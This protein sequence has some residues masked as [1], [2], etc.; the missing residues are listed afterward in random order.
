MKVSAEFIE[1]NFKVL[2]SGKLEYAPGVEGFSKVSTPTDFNGEVGS[3]WSLGMDGDIER[4]E[5]PFSAMEEM[6]DSH[7]NER[8]YLEHQLRDK[9][10]EINDL[11]D[12]LDGEN[13]FGSK[14]TAQ[15]EDWDD[16]DDW[17][18][19]NK[20]DDIDYMSDNRHD[21][22][23]LSFSTHQGGVDKPTFEKPE[24]E[25][26]AKSV[27]QQFPWMHDAGWQTDNPVGPYYLIIADHDAVPEGKQASKKTAQ[28]EGGE[29]KI[30]VDG[31]KQHGFLTVHMQDTDPGGDIITLN[32]DGTVRW[33]GFTT[34]MPDDF[35]D[36]TYPSVEAF[37][38]N[39]A[40]TGMLEWLATAAKG[41][42]MA[43]DGPD[44][45]EPDTDLRAYFSEED[46]D[47]G[48]VEASAKTAQGPEDVDEY[49]EDDGDD[50]SEGI[51]YVISDWIHAN[52]V[53]G[54]DWERDNHH[55]AELFTFSVART[56]T[57]E[58]MPKDEKVEAFAKS[59]QKQFPWMVDEGWQSS[60]PEYYYY[61][62]YAGH[63]EAEEAG[64]TASKK[65]AQP[66]ER[67][68]LQDAWAVLPIGLVSLRNGTNSVLGNMYEW[69]PDGQLTIVEREQGGI[70]VIAG[71]GSQAV[72][73]QA[74]MKHDQTGRSKG[75]VTV[76]GVVP[77]TPEGFEEA[78]GIVGKGSVGA[79]VW[80]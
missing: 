44:P 74:E 36:E 14:K 63:D 35:R 73:T 58:P 59:V 65:T 47:N 16:W 78:E 29:K 5:N 13:I 60:E 33:Q 19:A 76:I 15:D 11:Q 51:W 10:E 24:V 52:E 40:E 55:D 49:L 12:A 70:R 9:A 53:E 27:V 17:V 1:N 21:S 77:I 66:S 54:V 41:D 61:Q 45:L 80:K 3:I 32:E 2:A 26:F 64:S 4:E 43:S 22:E 62:L 8:Q 25:A 67:E 20:P 37:V 68:R 48:D 34:L 18:T 7:I 56:E 57:D 30:V 28:D 38:D 46:E 6:V 75:L 71:A 50:E 31:L 39:A 72:G 23:F 69:Q 79:Y 42:G